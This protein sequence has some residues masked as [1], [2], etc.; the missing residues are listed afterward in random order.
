MMIY[1]PHS[2]WQYDDDDDEDDDD[3]ADDADDDD[4]R[5]KRCINLSS[6]KIQL[7][8]ISCKPWVKKVICAAIFLKLFQWFFFKEVHFP[9]QRP[10]HLSMYFEMII[11]RFTLCQVLGAPSVPKSWVKKKDNQ[12]RATLPKFW[13]SKIR[14]FKGWPRGNGNNDG[15]GKEKHDSADAV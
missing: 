6:W 4:D 2:G 1:F 7:M 3:D 15:D 11:F 13:T 10:Q 8:Q 9:Y 14:L 12:N 5:Q